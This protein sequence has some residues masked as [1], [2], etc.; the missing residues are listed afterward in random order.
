MIF[1][2][3]ACATLEGIWGLTPEALNNISAEAAT[4]SAIAY[5]MEQLAVSFWQKWDM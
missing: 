2:A 1:G 5:G 4:I 3:I